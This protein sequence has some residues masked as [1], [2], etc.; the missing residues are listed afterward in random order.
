MRITGK[1]ALAL[2]LVGLLWSASEVEAGGRNRAGGGAAAQLLIP[3]GARDMALGGASSASTAG[4]EALHWN[5]A[6]LAASSSSATILVSTMSYLADMQLN[7]AAVGARFGSLGHLAVSMKALGVGDIPV[8]TAT[9]PDGTGGLFSPTFFTVGVTYAN[10]LTDRIRMGSTVHF[11]SENIGRTGASGI[12]FSAGVQYDNLGSVQGLDLGISIKH[13]G[14]RMT[15]G[16][17]GLLFPGQ[18][19]G[20]RRP[21]SFYRVEASSADLPSLFEI[22]L[23][24]RVPMGETQA[25][26]VNTLFQHQNYDYDEYR[27]GAEYIFNNSLVLRAGFEMPSSAEDDTFIFGTSFGAGL[28]LNIGAIRDLQL[29]YAYTGAQYFDALNTFAFKLD[30]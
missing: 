28:K 2:A 23:S 5:P 6:G 11:I 13:I 27:V 16:G 25:L 30:F 24:Y 20:L 29:D 9:S 8:T 21:G 3:V 19:E 14:T 17:P 7:Y 18:I 12:S 1:F 26:S 4:I 22:G 15:Y 10:S